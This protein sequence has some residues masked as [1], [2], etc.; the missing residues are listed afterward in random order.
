MP[1]WQSGWRRSTRVQLRTLGD[2]LSLLERDVDVERTPKS[3]MLLGQLVAATN[4]ALDTLA[5][6]AAG[7]YPPRLAADG[8]VAALTE[9]ASRA[10]G[11]VEMHESGVGRYPADV[12]AAVYFAVLEALQNVA[13]YADADSVTV[14]LTQDLDTLTF[15]VTDDGVGFDTAETTSGTG[16]Q[17]IVDRLDTVNGLIKIESTP[18]HGTAVTGTVPIVATPQD[19]AVP[20]LTGAHR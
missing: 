20:T 7:V 9:Q 16:L 6:L 17:G 11:P 5:S 12:E 18:G 8:L 19:D 15:V 2:Q 13:K 10:A 3:A 14:R 1:S 4:G